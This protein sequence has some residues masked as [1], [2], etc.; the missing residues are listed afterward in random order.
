MKSKPSPFGGLSLPREVRALEGE[1]GPSAGLTE[2]TLE[3]QKEAFEQGLSSELVPTAEE[4]ITALQS[5][6]EVIAIARQ[7][8][9]EA[10]S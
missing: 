5:V 1:C 9:H 2:K 7:N 6:S 3:E 4:G 10:E 8:L